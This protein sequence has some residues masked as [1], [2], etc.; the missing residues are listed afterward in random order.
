[1]PNNKKKQIQ[2]P[3]LNSTESPYREKA[4]HQ[5]PNLKSPNSKHQTTIKSPNIEKA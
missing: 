2:K 1:M 4:Q 5:K 3:K